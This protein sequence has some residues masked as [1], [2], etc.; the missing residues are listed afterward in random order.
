MTRRAND[1][2]ARGVRLSRAQRRW[3]ALRARP[4]RGAG[5]T[6]LEV[7][8][9]APIL[10]V[11]VLIGVAG[12]RAVTGQGRVDQAADVAARAASQQDTPAAAEPAAQAAAQRSLA[13]AGMD[14]RQL[15]LDV[16]LAGFDAPPGRPA[17]VTVT[18][19]C[20]VD[21][22]DLTLPGW[23]G[24]HTVTSSASSPLDEYREH[25]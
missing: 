24:R 23:P 3:R 25:P 1:R 18:V 12:G 6:S 16:D 20:I 8:L 21:W 19:R 7:I 14:C 17:V 15:T 11:L 13:Q 10:V 22:S 9:I 4:E 5:G 2:N